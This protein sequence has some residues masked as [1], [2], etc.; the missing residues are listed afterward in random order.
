[1]QPKQGITLQNSEKSV[2]N[3]WS[4]I[5][6]F[7]SNVFMDLGA[8]WSTRIQGRPPSPSFKTLLPIFKCD[9]QCLQS[10]R[11][12]HLKPMGEEYKLHLKASL[13]LY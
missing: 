8:T 9:G 1:M 2:A 5:T 10:N 11:S 6:F 4:P 3:E 7:F 12:I 13:N